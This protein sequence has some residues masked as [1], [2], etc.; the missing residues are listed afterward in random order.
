M[1]ELEHRPEKVTSLAKQYLQKLIVAEVLAVKYLPRSR[2]AT[3]AEL[4]TLVAALTHLSENHRG[5]IGARR[6]VPCA[7]ARMGRAARRAASTVDGTVYLQRAADPVPFASS[8]SLAQGSDLVT[9]PIPGPGRGCV[10]R[11]CAQAVVGPVAQ[12]SGS[13]SVTA[14]QQQ[15]ADS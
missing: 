2:W 1:G 15:R 6:P 3:P 8:S 13:G 12:V 10:G 9:H 14:M 4:P 11:G 5:L 7:G